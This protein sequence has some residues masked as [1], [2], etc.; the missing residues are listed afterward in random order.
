M[1]DKGGKHAHVQTRPITGSDLRQW[2]KSQNTTA[3]ILEGRLGIQRT[4]LMRWLNG[5][6][7]PP[8]YLVLALARIECEQ[9]ERD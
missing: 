7:N 9:R 1:I 4:T 2:I 8:P 5:T 3:S 6:T